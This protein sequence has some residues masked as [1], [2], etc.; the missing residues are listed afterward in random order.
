MT[1]FSGQ[2]E[3]HVGRL[4]ALHPTV[5]D[6]SAVANGTVGE[7]DG[8]V[9]NESYS[10]RLAE[11]L[12]SLGGNDLVLVVGLLNAHQNGASLET[13]SEVLQSQEGRVDDVLKQF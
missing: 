5:F 6:A 2:I 8:Q 12:F 7:A 3:A 10:E 9:V 4:F 13:M 1:A 11:D